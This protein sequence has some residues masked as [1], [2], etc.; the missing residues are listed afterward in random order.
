MFID[1][2]TKCHDNE[3]VVVSL[4]NFE[5]RTFDTLYDR[6][7]PYILTQQCD[8]NRLPTGRGI[9]SIGSSIMETGCSLF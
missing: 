7:A 9:V 2:H 1:H 6:Q 3:V 5:P 4:N 8:T